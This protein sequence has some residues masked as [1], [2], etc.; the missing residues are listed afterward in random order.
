MSHQPLFFL[1]K[2]HFFEWQ[3]IQP[4]LD[5]LGNRASFTSEERRLWSSHVKLALVIGRG[6]ISCIQD[7]EL[8]SISLLKDDDHRLEAFKHVANVEKGSENIRIRS[9]EHFWPLNISPLQH[10]LVASTIVAC[11]PSEGSINNPEVFLCKA[12]LDSLER[13]DASKVHDQI[14]ISLCDAR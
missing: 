1:P 2:F 9:S 8:Q 7:G 10:A 11:E 6:Q 4:R 14:P 12:F 5:A 3:L 13:Y